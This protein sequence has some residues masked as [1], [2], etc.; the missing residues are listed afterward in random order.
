[1]DRDRLLAQLKALGEVG[2]LEMAI[3]L[4]GGEY[5]VSELL[6]ILGVTQ[7]NLSRQVKVLREAGVVVERREG[8]NVFY[9]LG[10]NE[11]TGTVVELAAR[12]TPAE[13]S[14]RAGGGRRDDRCAGALSRRQITYIN[15]H[16]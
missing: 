14:E 9:R 3:T 2:R 16:I 5:G 15:L 13:A 8:R 11:L 12:S 1:M 4:A 6:E 7:P 10:D